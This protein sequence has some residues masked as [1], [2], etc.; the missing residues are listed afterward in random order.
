MKIAALIPTYNRRANVLRAIDSVLAQTLPVAEIIVVDDGSTDGTGDAIDARYGSAVTLIRQGNGGVSVARTRAME[1]AR[2][3]WVAFLDS[4]DVWFP[5]K[6]ERQRDALRALGDDFGACFTNCCYSGNPAMFYSVFDQG[7]LRLAAGCEVAALGNPLRYIVG[8]HGRYAPSLMVQSLLVRR[9]LLREMGGFDSS[10][11]FSE[12]RD[13]TFRLCFNTKLCVVSTPLVSIDRTPGV[14]RL[15]DGLACKNDQLYAWLELVLK[16]ML[17]Q[18][19]RLDPDSVK[20]IRD[21]L[22]G[23][24]YGGVAER[25]RQ[26]EFVAAYRNLRKLRHMGQSYPKVA[27]NLFA[28]AGRKLTNTI[29]LPGNLQSEAGGIFRDA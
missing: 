29:D 8:A 7:G 25:L 13:L 16:K 6:L 11:G 18:S 23:L 1:E 24:Y 15:T 9:S 22:M 17:S 4:D 19:D 21:E 10:L 2:S 14:S 12:D 5:T 27:F 28:R 3:E 20:T 26:R